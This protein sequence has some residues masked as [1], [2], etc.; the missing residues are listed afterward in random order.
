[1]GFAQES[2]ELLEHFGLLPPNVE[3]KFY[4][5]SL[6]LHF[7]PTAGLPIFEQTRIFLESQLV[8]FLFLDIYR[9]AKFQKKLINKFQ[10]K[11]VRAAR[12]DALTVKHEFIGLPCQWK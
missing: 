5:N 1:M 2:R 11:L 4:G 3:T 9:C 6:K 8:T 12:T 10:E 7:K